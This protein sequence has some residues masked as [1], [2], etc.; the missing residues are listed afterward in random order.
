[1]CRASFTVQLVKNWPAMQEDPGSTPGT[2]R[3]TGEGI[4]YPFQYS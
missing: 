1:M 2:E 3:P 4:G